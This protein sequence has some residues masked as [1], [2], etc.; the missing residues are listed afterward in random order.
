VNDLYETRGTKF[1]LSLSGS[2]KLCGLGLSTGH[3]SI[4]RWNTGRRTWLEQ[5]WM[6]GE[7]V[8]SKRSSASTT[9]AEASIAW[10]SW[11]P[12]RESALLN[13]A[14][15]RQKGDIKDQLYYCI[16][17][18]KQFWVLTFNRNPASGTIK[19]NVTA[20]VILNKVLTCIPPIASDDKREFRDS[21]A[22]CRVLR[23][24]ALSTETQSLKFE[25]S[26]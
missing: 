21:S 26:A 7:V 23:H 14:C 18:K 16:V 8:A 9:M 19:N 4:S 2:V 6:N 15:I 12:R 1:V 3:R 17:T 25:S 10:S 11:Q 24:F 22:I 5:E 20:N 13:L